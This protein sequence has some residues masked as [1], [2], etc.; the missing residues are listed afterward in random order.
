MSK[1]IASR[2]ND[3]FLL[4]VPFFW[5]IQNIGMIHIICVLIENT[6]ILKSATPQTD[7]QSHME[8]I[9]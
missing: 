5:Q 7:L 6:L 1:S 8:R 4:R 3:V 9:Q 2:V